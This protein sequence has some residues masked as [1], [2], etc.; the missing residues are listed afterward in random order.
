[1]KTAKFAC[2]LMAVAFLMASCG[3]SNSS[4]T[5]GWNYND[6]NWGGFDVAD[7]NEQV[8][9][10]GLVFIEGGSFVMGRVADDSRFQWN[11]AAHTVTVSSF[12]LD[13]TEVT[14]LAYREFVY[15]MGRAFG[16][17]FPEKVNA[18]RPDV[19]AWRDKLAW[20]ESAVDYYFESPIY[21][22]YPVVGV[23][24]EQATKYCKWRTDRVNEKILVDRGIITLNVAELEGA[25]A[26][27]TDVYLAGQY[28]SEGG[29]MLTDLDPAAGGEGRNVRKSDG[30]LSP[31]YRLPTE[32]EWEFAALGMIGNTVDERIVEHKVY[33]W[34]GHSLRSAN[35]KYYG[36]FLANFK[37]S[38]GDAMG[39]AGNL[40]DGWDYTAPVK[41]YFPN[42]YGLYQMA[43]NVS[44]WCMDVYRKD[45]NPVG[46]EDLDPFRGNIYQELV[47]EDGEVARDEE[48]GDLKYKNI[49]DQHNR[50]NYRQADNV[51]YLD[52]DYASSIF[53]YNGNEAIVSWV[54]EE[55]EEGEEGAEEE[56][57]EGAVDMNDQDAVTNLMYRRNPAN[58]SEVTSLLN[59]K[60]RV[61]KGGSWADRA[62]WMQA[63]TRRFY[64]QD[65]STAWIGFRCA[66]DRIGSQTGM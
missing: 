63:G 60:V 38:R 51:N 29:Q 21:A 1:M 36:Q 46:G 3:K 22:E 41:W 28:E 53:D 39:V 19:N 26:F 10:P 42:D 17:E 56:A 62:F 18:I 57:E 13:E 15:W 61:V 48:S 16:E 4:A 37:R 20:R 12:Y 59:N 27:Q 49:E 32:A 52:G 64:D 9:A 23:S 58:K 11:N 5:T 44:E 66:M 54:K 35:K 2:F 65:K 40:N 47:M 25:S 24:W 7:V 8:A 45:V 43:G 6:P 14:N 30:I 31:S 34:A 33:P 50:R 55:A